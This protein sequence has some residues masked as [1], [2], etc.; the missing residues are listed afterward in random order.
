MSS[1]VGQY[2]VEL[3]AAN[4]IDTVFGIPGVHNLELYRGLSGTRLRHVLVRHEQ[5]AGFAADGFARMS[6]RSAAAFVI[7]GPGFTNILTAAAQAYSDSVPL[8]VIAS[9]PPRA[10]LGKNWGVLHELRDQLGIAAG[11]FGVARAA[12]SAADVRDHLRACF[13]ALRFGRPRPAYLE[14]PLDLLA[15]T[16]GLEAQTFELPVIQPEP[17]PAQI[18]AAVRLLA[19]AQRPFI[20]A[21]GGARRAGAELSEL[22][23]RLGALLVTTAAGKGVL[24]DK[25]PAHLGAALPY[26]EVQ[27]LA[28]QADVV[29]AV[30]TELGETD[31]YA[32]LK[33]ELGGRLIRVDVDASRLCDPYAAGVPVWGDAVSSLAAINRGLARDG[34]AG[35]GAGRG[36]PAAAVRARIDQQILSGDGPAHL[37]VLG[38]IRAALPADAAV[39]SDMTQ[40]AYLGNY[41]YPVDAPGCWFHPSGYGTLG[42]A[43]PAAL[44]AKIAAPG[45]AVLALVGDYG[46]Q[47]TLNELMTA[48]EADRTLPVVIWNNAALGQIRDDMKVANIPPLG[49]VGLNP[50]FGALAAA[51]GAAAERARTPTQLTSAVRAALE[52]RGP[53]L[54]EAVR[55]DFLQ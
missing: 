37:Q 51:Y 23:G 52:R 44:G 25:H 32:A 54:I 14:V 19:A 21:G 17:Q 9:T 41:A 26:R 40:I 6:G 15:E 10:S 11:V 35:G 8:L 27:A 53:T 48:V 1:T 34:G 49:V 36:G 42:F 2:L 38:A 43:L 45:R 16:T 18:A 39:F 5:G 55:E 4:G 24:A 31:L 50:D 30:G 46:L 33:L 12:R 22:V 3:L 7:S 28:A 20:I 29:L 13:A 47:F